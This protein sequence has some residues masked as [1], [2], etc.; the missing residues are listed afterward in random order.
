MR[1]LY[2]LGKSMIDGPDGIAYFTGHNVLVK[3]GGVQIDCGILFMGLANGT[4]HY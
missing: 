1:I 3:S 4:N 2:D